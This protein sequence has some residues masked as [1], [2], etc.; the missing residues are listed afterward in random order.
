[1]NENECTCSLPEFMSCRKECDFKIGQK[2]KRLLEQ[3]APEM[4]EMLQQ[5]DEALDALWSI[6]DKNIL[7]DYLDGID[8][9]QLI[10]QATQI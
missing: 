8:T 1:M 4:L 9:K 6:D 7:F 10:K 2:K 3:K 5:I